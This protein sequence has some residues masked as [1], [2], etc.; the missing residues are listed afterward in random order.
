MYSIT[1]TAI[2]ETLWN[3]ELNGSNVATVKGATDQEALRAAA[4]FRDP[5]GAKLREAEKQEAVLTRAYVIAEANLKA[6]ERARGEALER[7]MSTIKCTIRQE[8]I[9]AGKRAAEKNE[10]A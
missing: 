4:D 3:V 10:T 1:L 9:L 8:E 6:A 5:E 2:S 7:A